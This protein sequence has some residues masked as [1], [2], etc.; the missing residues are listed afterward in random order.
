MADEPRSCVI[1]DR[2]VDGT[3]VDRLKD[4]RC[5]ACYQYR[6]RHG[7]DRPDPFDRLVDLLYRPAWIRDGLCN[8][9]PDLPSVA[10]GPHRFGS[11]C[12]AFAGISS[13]FARPS[14]WGAGCQSRSAS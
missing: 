1:C 11:S 3:D 5:A 10:C 6:Q 2:W 13:A 7:H 12:V 9:Y 4:D 8:E 14:P